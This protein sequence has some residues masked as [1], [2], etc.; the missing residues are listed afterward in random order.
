MHAAGR[1]TITA[2]GRHGTTGQAGR[3]AECR[4]TAS[5][6]DA[7]VMRTGGCRAEPCMPALRRRSAA[8][9]RV[10]P[11]AL[12]QPDLAPR[13]GLQPQTFRLLRMM[14]ACSRLRPCQPPHHRHRL[15]GRHTAS[16]RMQSP[17]VLTP[18][19]RH[20]WRS[21]TGSPG[22]RMRCAAL[23]AQSKKGAIAE[24]ARLCR[25]S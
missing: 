1:R 25:T 19:A 10:R 6:E 3:Q 14:P 12:R 8:C 4:L 7:A 2:S 20:F 17:A 18:S 16:M 11:Q 22:K 24:F 13:T 15:A 21:L 23:A 9:T 5:M